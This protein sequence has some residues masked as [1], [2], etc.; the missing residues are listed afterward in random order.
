M[1]FF[2]PFN[3]IGD[4]FLNTCLGFK[5]EEFPGLVNISPGFGHITRRAGFHF[6]DGLFAEIF[7]VGFL[8]PAFSG[9]RDAFVFAL[10]LIILLIRPY[11]ILGTA[12][13]AA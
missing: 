7:F 2:I 6:L 1:I 4:T 10:L 5:P 8:P 11:G 12:E 3:K 9:Y 13:E